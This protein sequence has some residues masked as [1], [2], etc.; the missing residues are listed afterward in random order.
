MTGDA[1]GAVRRQRTSVTRGC[2]RACEPLVGATLRGCFALELV[3]PLGRLLDS[4][5]RRPPNGHESKGAAASVVRQ[6]GVGS[7]EKT[8]MPGLDPKAD[9]ISV[10]SHELKTPINV[11]LGYLRLL[12][13][14]IY[15]PLTSRQTEVC[16]TIERQCQAVARLSEQLLE[17]SR[18]EAGGGRIDPRPFPLE[19][20]LVELDTSFQVLG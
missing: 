17:V 10:A 20:F 18:F 8:V 16:Q 6:S 15:G 12:Q 2:Q 9:L 13:E 4:F 11:M 3:M 5:L 14:G 19:A 7:R 1:D